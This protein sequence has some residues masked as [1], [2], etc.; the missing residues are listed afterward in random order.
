MGIQQYKSARYSDAVLSFRKA[1]DLD[2]MNPNIH[3]YLGTACMS[4]YIPGAETPDNS[5]QVACAEAEFRR[6]LDIDNRDTIALA[7]LASLAYQQAQGMQDIAAKSTQLRVAADW[8][9]R[10]TTVDPNNKEPYYSLGV[11]AWAQAYPVIMTARR[12]SGMRPEDPGTL[13]NPA[14]RAAL[15]ARYSSSIA[16][17][18]SNLDQAMRID[19]NYDDAMAYMNLLL[20]LK[21]YLSDTDAEYSQETAQANQW[22]QRA[23]DTR[24]SKAL[25]YPNHQPGNANGTTTFEGSHGPPPPPPPPPSQNPQQPQKIRVGANVQAS[26]LIR[27]APP[28][29]PPLAVQARV[30]GTVRFT[31]TIGRDGNIDNL[32]LVSGHPLLVNSAQEAVKQYQYKPTL[33]NGQPVEVVTQVD[34]NFTLPPN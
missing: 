19:P 16:A 21:S 9:Q 15:Q 14:A 31:V 6:V 8:Y 7:S 24:R 28:V 32:Q 10:L 33:L 18:M 30:Q 25:S 22:V 26:N 3:L 29:Y 17:G 34:V 11:I 13:K 23:L 1:A 4:Q 27:S 5:A 20:R 2:P 12:D